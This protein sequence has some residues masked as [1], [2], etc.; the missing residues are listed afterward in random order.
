MAVGRWG[1]ITTSVRLQLEQTSRLPHRKRR[2]ASAL[3][4]EDKVKRLG[5]HGTIR[6]QRHFSGTALPYT[7][8]PY[9]HTYMYIIKYMCILLIFEINLE[10]SLFAALL[11]CI[12]TAARKHSF[13]TSE[14]AFESSLW[15]RPKNTALVP[16]LCSACFCFKQCV[17]CV[18]IRIKNSHSRVF[19][20]YIFVS[21]NVPFYH[22]TLLYNQLVRY[23]YI[24][25]ES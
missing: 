2:T 20:Y 16:L 24:L 9:T 25:S 8:N 5:V 21:F 18:A 19:L 23:I 6:R 3:N 14:F 22:C 11:C 10:T 12:S 7:R 4:E 15:Y 13:K 1:V 17:Y